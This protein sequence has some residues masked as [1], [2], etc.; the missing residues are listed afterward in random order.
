MANMTLSKNKFDYLFGIRVG[1]KNITYTLSVNASDPCE[2]IKDL[3]G[4]LIS[5]EERK[6]YFAEG[7]NNTVMIGNVAATSRYNACK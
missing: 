5:L 1:E 7:E 6:S 3:K 4:A 2:A